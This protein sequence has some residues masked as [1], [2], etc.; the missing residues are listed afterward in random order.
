MS[1]ELFR[2]VASAGKQVWVAVHGAGGWLAAHG[3]EV[4]R[5]VNKLVADEIRATLEPL[6]DENARTP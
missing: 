3:R 5:R 2:T 6:R 1:N 4:A